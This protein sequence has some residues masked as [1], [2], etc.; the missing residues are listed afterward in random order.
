MQAKVCFEVHLFPLVSLL[1]PDAKF[2]LSLMS[3]WCCYVDELLAMREAE[4]SAG[5]EQD[6][7]MDAF[8]KAQ[9]LEG[10]TESI[11]TEYMLKLLGLDVSAS[12]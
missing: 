1:L 5:K 11:V 4:K 7:V 2:N 8:L 3:K 9:T 10:G 12:V 6:P